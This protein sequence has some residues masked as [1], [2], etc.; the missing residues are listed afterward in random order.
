MIFTDL[1]DSLLNDEKKVSQI[2]KD[3]I[4]KIQE[5]GVKFI[6]ASGRPT[7]AMR[8]LGKELQLEKF[9]G[10]LL[11]YNGS[12][13]TDCK[14]NEDIFK[15]TLNS[16]DLHLMYDFAKKHNVHILTYTDKEIISE[17]DSEYIDVEV[18]LTH[19]THRKVEDF[20]KFVDFSATKCMMLAEPSY[21]KEV[22]K[23]LKK[24]YG[25]KYT[26]AISK[27]FFLEVTMANIDKGIALQKLAEHLNIPVSQTIAL[28]DSYN[29]LPML[30][31]AGLPVCV[32]NA[33]EDI[34]KV[35]KFTTK[36]NNNGGMAHL[37]KT[38]F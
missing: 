34:K 12:I 8:E 16:E 7:I 20:K 36:S 37:I 26:I 1:D 29:D 32:E 28:G 15:A 23:E 3:A 19:M 2:D 18:N 17:T 10:Y 13:I 35:C 14:T 4:L 30:K 6:L 27:P 9:G 21:L 31:M 22:E 5:K 25:D 38:F 24:E 33:N 11:S